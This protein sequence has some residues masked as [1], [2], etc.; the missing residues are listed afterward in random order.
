[1]AILEACW[2]TFETSLATAQGRELRKGPR[3]GELNLVGIRH[4]VLLS[5]VSYLRRLDW[6]LTSVDVGGN[7]P[8]SKQILLAYEQT[9]EMVAH[10]GFP[11]I[12]TWGGI[13]WTCA[14]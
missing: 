14:A 7:P 6:K 10:N 4:P 2:Q 12:G 8:L 11:A 1:M 13:I 9:V 5:A 3:G